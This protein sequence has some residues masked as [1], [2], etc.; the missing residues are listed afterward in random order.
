MNAIDFRHQWKTKQNGR[1]CYIYCDTAHISQT[2]L[3]HTLVTVCKILPQNLIGMQ[4]RPT[5]WMLLIFNI[6][7]KKQ[8]GH[9]R[10]IYCNTAYIIHT[11]KVTVWKISP[12]NL[13]GM[14]NRPIEWMVLIFSKIR[15]TKWPPSRHILQRWTH[16][17]HLPC[18]P[19]KSKSLKDITTK[20]DRHVK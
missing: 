20:L 14:S 2:E 19:Y 4:D 9:Y 18:T 6:N 17:P 15:K 3:V 16:L 12:Q 10:D 8:N 5:E 7:E 11:L 13:I 1:H